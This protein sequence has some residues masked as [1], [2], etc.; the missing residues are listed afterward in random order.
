MWQDIQHHQ[1]ATPAGCLALDTHF[2]I[3]CAH[4]EIEQLNGE[5]W[6]M[7]TY[8]QDEDIY[9]CMQEHAF[10]DINPPLAHQIGVYCM[11]RGQFNVSDQLSFAYVGQGCVW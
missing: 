6:W 9:L 1:W 4:K 8:I 7:A 3:I 10:Q 2:K 5:V 11:V